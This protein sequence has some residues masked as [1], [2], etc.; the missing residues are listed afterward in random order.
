MIR[1]AFF[2]TPAEAVPVLAGLREVAEVGLVVTQPD[3]PRGRS[4]TP[5]PPP[6]KLAAAAWGLGVVQPARPGE[7]VDLLDGTDVA[8]L[9][10]Y[11]RLVPAA[12]LAVPRRGFVNIHYSLLP[13]WRGASPVVRAI[14]AGDEETGVTLMEMDQGLDTGGIISAKRAPIGAEETAGELT[15]R[16][17]DLGSRLVAEVLPAWVEG[18]ITAIPQDGSLA[19]AAA[20]VTIDEA[21]V[22][23]ARH[24]A[25]AVWRAVRAFNPR[26]GAWGVVEGTRHKLWRVGPSP[27]PG[28][29]PG[30][31]SV[32]GGRVI[33]GCADGAVEV[34]RIQPAGRA[35]MSARS[36]MHGRRGEPA[37]FIAPT[38]EPATPSG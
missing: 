27:S 34:L 23:P 16:L 8:V 26:P 25:E 19:T 31:A 4:G 2:G 12:L 18:S 33:L 3:R 37:R 36:W 32:I 1:A 38:T 24:T 9:A 15:E 13:R 10:A 11:G 20:K 29:A 21:F 7:I 6:V 35:E 17:A 28:V 30:I 14:L 5:Q 22:M